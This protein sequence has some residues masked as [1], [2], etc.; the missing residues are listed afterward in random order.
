MG[1]NASLEDTHLKI[2]K[3]A[4]TLFPGLHRHGASRLVRLDDPEPCQNAIPKTSTQRTHV[5]VAPA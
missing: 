4:K 5:T 3:H 2:L 1:G